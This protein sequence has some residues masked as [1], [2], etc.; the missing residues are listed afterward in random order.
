MLQGPG[1]VLNNGDEI[2][3]A[4]R[5]AWTVPL[6]LR[7]RIIARP[8][9]RSGERLDRFL[10]VGGVDSFSTGALSFMRPADTHR[11]HPASCVDIRPAVRIEPG[12]RH[13]L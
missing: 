5:Q 11:R 10:R 12:K 3:D 7:A 13:V 1:G 2:D 8:S 9:L 4:P 6:L